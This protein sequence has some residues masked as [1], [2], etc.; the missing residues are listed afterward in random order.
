MP[1]PGAAPRPSRKAESADLWSVS[2]RGESETGSGESPNSILQKWQIESAG[3][4]A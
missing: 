3:G 4:L 2:V 1:M